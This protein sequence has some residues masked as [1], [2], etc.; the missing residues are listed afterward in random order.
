MFRHAI[1]AGLGLIVLTGCEQFFG[2]G[3]SYQTRIAPERTREIET[4]ELQEAK[5][6][7]KAPADVNDV[8]EVPPKELELTLEKCRAENSVCPIRYIPKRCALACTTIISLPLIVT[9]SC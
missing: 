1:L 9:S 5:D 3:N 6:E 4:L 2:D 7:E 8:N